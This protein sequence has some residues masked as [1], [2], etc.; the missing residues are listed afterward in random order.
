MGVPVQKVL[1][2]CCKSDPHVSTKT[3]CLPV[4]YFSF[5]T[6]RGKFWYASTKNSILYWH[7][8]RGFYDVCTVRCLL[9]GCVCT[10]VSARNSCPPGSSGWYAQR[11]RSSVERKV[12]LI[13]FL[14]IG[15]PT[16]T[17]TH[18]SQ[19]NSILIKA[20]TRALR[21]FETDILSRSTPFSSKLFP[22]S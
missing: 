3:H 11:V 13:W 22:E 7:M 12:S 10:W 9:F 16:E 20:S 2:V 4:Y 19:W 14:F 1:P 8:D 18:P 5:C 17:A 6:G 21:L 15:S